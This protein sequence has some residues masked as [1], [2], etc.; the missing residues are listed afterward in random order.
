M[1]LYFWGF[2]PSNKSG[3]YRKQTIALII[4]ALVP[5]LFNLSYILKIDVLSGLDLTPF[6][7]TLS[8][9]I[10]TFTVFRYHLLDV[11]NVARNA[12]VE[13]M[14]DGILVVNSE[15]KIID[16]NSSLEKIS[17]LTKAQAVGSDLGQVWRKID[18]I[19]SG[20]ESGQ[21]REL[22]ALESGI[23]HDLDVSLTNIYGQHQELAGQLVMMRDITEARKMEQTIRESEKRYS[24]LIE[25][26]S[27]GVL[28]IQNGIYKF[29]NRTMQKI[30]GYPPD[31]FIG[32]TV[33]FPITGGTAQFLQQQ[34]SR[35]LSGELVPDNYDVSMIR[36][37]GIKIEC[38]LTLGSITY[39]GSALIW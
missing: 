23:N 15:N 13:Q 21:H 1:G 18:R 34:H 29:A 24:T 16:M 11:R 37:D 32:Q 14:P 19:K 38:E 30:T 9:V 36:K 20:M 4:G 25:Q 8:A 28:I 35:R 7:I 17:G 31:E 10:Y 3:P 33:G 26:S 12:L 27:D 22:A 5:I 2:L 6:S 39:N